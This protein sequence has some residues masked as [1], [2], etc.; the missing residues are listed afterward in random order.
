MPLSKA[1][2]SFEAQ[3]KTQLAEAILP[4]SSSGESSLTIERRITMLTPSNTPLKKSADI[5]SIKFF[6][7][8]KIMMLNPNPAIATRRFRP[9]RSMGGWRVAIRVMIKA[10]REGAALS[11]PSPLAPTC[12]MS[13]AYMGSNMIAPPKN[14]ENRSR[15]IDTHKGW[16]L[17]RNF[18]PVPILLNRDSFLQGGAWCLGGMERVNTQERMK[19][20]VMTR[21]D[22]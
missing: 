13:L 22:P 16:V 2:N 7:N 4:R 15:I 17:K 8:A 12:S 11:S 5:D 18:H 3:T 10:P 6:E 21:Y 9:A 19:Q 1:P 20:A 14:T